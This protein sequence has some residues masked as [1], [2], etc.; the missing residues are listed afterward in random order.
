MSSIETNLRKRNAAVTAL[1]DYYRAAMF[2]HPTAK[3]MNQEVLKIKAAH[4][5]KAPT[6]TRAFFEGVND[7][8]IKSLYESRLVFGGYVGDVF[9]ST[10][11]QRADYY[12]KHGIEPSEYADNGRVKARGHYWTDDSG[13]VGKPYFTDGV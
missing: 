9:Y 12:E 13:N 6:W 5:A 7:Q 3:E 4:L 2:Y 1:R 8:L 11:R 10:Y